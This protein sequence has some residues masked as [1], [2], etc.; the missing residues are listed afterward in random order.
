MIIIV[1]VKKTNKNSTLN[2]L[3]S[4][5]YRNNFDK[6]SKNP[7]SV[8]KKQFFSQRVRLKTPKRLI[9]LKKEKDT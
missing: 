8:Q 4:T 1:L 2:F 5:M 3:R 6:A 7:V 9:R